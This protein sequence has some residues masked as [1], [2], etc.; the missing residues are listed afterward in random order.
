MEG[1]CGYWV[2]GRGWT[3]EIVRATKV[4]RILCKSFRILF[5]VEY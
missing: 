1:V 4:T 2:D 5:A 3:I